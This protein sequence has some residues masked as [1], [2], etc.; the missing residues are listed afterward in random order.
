MHD[1]GG[2]GRSHRGVL[3]HEGGPYDRAGS[4]KAPESVLVVGAHARVLLA[5]LAAVLG[6]DVLS[7][8]LREVMLEN[9]A[10][11]EALSLLLEKGCKS[12]SEAHNL[13]DRGSVSVER[14]VHQS[15]RLL[16]CGA[17]ALSL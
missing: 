1:S 15:A 13:W 6:A 11:L 4:Q 17:E 3:A 5:V 10:C 8:S 9:D 14:D 2:G 7:H 16:T 12:K